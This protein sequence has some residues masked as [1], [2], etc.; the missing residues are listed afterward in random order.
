VD[1]HTEIASDYVRWCVYELDH[2][3]ADNVGGRMAPVGD[4]AFGRAVALATSSP[5]GV[6]G[7]RF[8][9]SDR[10]EW[11]DTVYMGAWPREVFERVGGFDEQFVRNQ[12]DEFNYRLLSSGGKILLSPR[13]RSRYHNRSTPGS[14]WRQYR[15]Y[16][17]WKVRVMQ[18][19]PSQMRARQFV[20]PT[21]A[22]VLVGSVVLALF[23]GLGRLLLA[24]VAGTYLTAN[25]VASLWTARRDW[26]TL[27]LLP[28]A[29]SIL[30][31]A[32]GFGFLWGLWK[33]RKECW[34]EKASEPVCLQRGAQQ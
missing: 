1:G 24:G 12:D 13:I 19:H 20:P 10:R 17:Y 27:P 34:G 14:L 18:K 4:G 23:A 31:L 5:F 3:E 15:Q 9:Y 16:G 22:A 32:Y 21:F 7:G 29:F 30:H 11:V 28:L 8:H 2:T 6:G 25:L 33:W 26:R